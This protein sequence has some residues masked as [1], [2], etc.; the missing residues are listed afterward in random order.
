MAQNYNYAL[1]RIEREL[2][3]IENNPSV[4]YSIWQHKDNLLKFNTNIH[5]LPDSRYDGKNYEIEITLPHEYPLKPPQV[6]FITAI[7]NENVD[8]Y[9]GILCADI[10]GKKWSPAYTLASLMISVVS[11]LTDGQPSRYSPRLHPTL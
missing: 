6:K 8:T 4:Y 10:L 7:K 11:L 9:T 5:C 3:H 2:N 1:K